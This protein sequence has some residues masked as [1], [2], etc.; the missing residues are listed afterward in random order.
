VSKGDCTREA[1]FS[2]TKGDFF[3]AD[4]GKELVMSAQGGMNSAV[5]MRNYQR[6]CFGG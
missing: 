3:L 2:A 5:L 6:I 1:A 4:I